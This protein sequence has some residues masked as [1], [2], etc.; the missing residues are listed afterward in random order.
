MVADT[1]ETGNISV[2]AIHELIKLV[3]EERGLEK[4]FSH[5]YST[6]ILIDIIGSNIKG[7]KYSH[8]V[9]V[10]ED[11]KQKRGFVGVRFNVERI[12]QDYEEI[13]DENAHQY[14]E[15]RKELG[16]ESNNSTSLL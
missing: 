10:G 11:T 14:R 15:L 7:A 2:Q 1:S 16:L 9:R 8:H 5:K 6:Q 13:L 12:L 3:S 4:A